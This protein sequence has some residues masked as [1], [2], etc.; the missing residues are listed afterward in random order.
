MCENSVSTQAFSGCFCKELFLVQLSCIKVYRWRS[1]LN[2]KNDAASC[3]LWSPTLCCSCTV[4]LR[5]QSNH[6][7]MI[8]K[9]SDKI[10][11][12]TVWSQYFFVWLTSLTYQIIDQRKLEVTESFFLY[13]SAIQSSTRLRSLFSKSPVHIKGVSIL[14]PDLT[15]CSNIETQSSRLS[16]ASYKPK[17]L[18]MLENC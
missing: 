14:D 1:W 18:V 2:F 4:A 9:L 13:F 10:N 16:L 11:I 17:G 15:L 8:P 6:C 12:D 7:F 3:G 5:R